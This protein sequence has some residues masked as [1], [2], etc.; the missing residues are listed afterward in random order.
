MIHTIDYN[1]IICPI[2]IKD[3]YNKFSFVDQKNISLKMS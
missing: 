1:K 3:K 2:F